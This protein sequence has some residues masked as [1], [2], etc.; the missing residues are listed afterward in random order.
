M[1]WSPKIGHTKLQFL[2][3]ISDMKHKPWL[4]IWRHFHFAPG[5]DFWLKK[6]KTCQGLQ[7]RVLDILANGLFKNPIMQF[8]Q[9]QEVRDL[10]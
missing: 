3:C 4:Q 10:L 9:Q 6:K 2:T 1:E 7:E 5:Q 8:P